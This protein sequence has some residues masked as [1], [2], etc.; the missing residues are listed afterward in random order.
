MM[1]VGIL[2]GIFGLRFSKLKD[3]REQKAFETNLRTSLVDELKGMNAEFRIDLDR[4]KA[5]NKA[6]IIQIDGLEGQIDT[7]LLKVATAQ[8]TAATEQ[9]K[10]NERVDN[11]VAQVADEVKE[12]QEQIQRCQQEL[13]KK[14]KE[15]IELRLKYQ[16][17]VVDMTARIKAEIIADLGLPGPAPMPTRHPPTAGKHKPNTE[18]ELETAPDTDTTSTATQK[19]AH[20]DV[21]N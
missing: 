14:D 10:H 11:L 15:I 12:R 21:R 8:A 6:L 18:A 20:N 9:Q 4:V 16:S 7:L 17:H 1:M 19:K 5:E 2:G 3:T 13:A